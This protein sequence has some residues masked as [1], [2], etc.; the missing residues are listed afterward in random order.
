MATNPFAFKHSVYQIMPTWHR[1]SHLCYVDAIVQVSARTF[2]VLPSTPSS[3]SFF[4]AVSGLRHV[5]RVVS[6]DI[7]V[8]EF[9]LW[10]RVFKRIHYATWLCHAVSCQK[11][12]VIFAYF[13][14]RDYGLPSS[15]SAIVCN[16][17]KRGKNHGGLFTH[18]H[19]HSH[20]PRFH[21]C[22]ALRMRRASYRLVPPSRILRILYLVIII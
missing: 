9:F 1:W 14:W 15:R 13:F 17:N 7:K 3:R 4:F 22:E 10:F 5:A 18:T 20:A 8:H 2:G 19:T 16:G 11:T 6:T 21:V 12:S